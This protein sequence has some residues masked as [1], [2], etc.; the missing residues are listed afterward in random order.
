MGWYLTPE[1]NEFWR[2]WDGTA[3]TFYLRS[4]EKAPPGGARAPSL[5]A[6]SFSVPA[7]A[8]QSPSPRTTTLPQPSLPDP[9]DL[10]SRVPAQSL[11]EKLTGFVESGELRI[12]ANP[13]KSFVSK[14]AQSWYVGALGER[15]VAMVLRGLPSEWTVLHS[16]PVGRGTSD[17]DHVVIG[18]AGV[19]TLNTK[20]HAGADAWVGDHAM[21][22]AGAPVDYLRKSSHEAWRASQALSRASGLTVPVTGLITL[23]GVRRLNVKQR[24]SADMHVDVV[25]VEHL[26]TRLQTRR[27][28]SDEQVARVAAAASRFG[29][30]HTGNPSSVDI[31]PALAQLDIAE[32]TKSAPAGYTPVRPQ[33]RRGRRLAVGCLAVIGGLFTAYAAVVLSAY[34]IWHFTH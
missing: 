15:H 29:T 26:L 8:T 19:F 25:P 33:R 22:V 23:V 14:D 18:P 28:F 27:E 10:R 21:Y 30:W 9:H 4:V 6:P 11:L 2:W 7:D 32:S 17:I 20:H 1:N 12:D 16:V 34:A 24:P 13:R 3:W 5:T 31:S